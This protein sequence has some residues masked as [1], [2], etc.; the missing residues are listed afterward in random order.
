MSLAKNTFYS[1][2]TQLPVQFFGIIS[3]ILLTRM[4][5]VE[6]KGVFAIYNANAQ[7]LITFFSFSLSSSIAFFISSKKI[8]FEKMFGFGLLTFILGSILAIL[9]VILIHIFSHNSLFFPTEYHNVLYSLW[10]ITM[11]IVSIGISII[12]GFYVGL[13]R[14][15]DINRIAIVNSIVNLLCFSFVF[16]LYKY[17][18]VDASP[19]LLLYALFFITLFN[20]I[21]FLYNFI[22]FY[23]KPEIKTISFSEIKSIFN[24]TILS[25]L[26]IFVN[27]FN[28]RISLWVLAYYLDEF[29]IGIYSLAAN[30]AAIFSVISTPIANVMMPYLAEESKSIRDSI[31][32]R[33]S[34]LNFSV[35]LFVMLIAFLISD[36]LIPLVYGADFAESSLLFKVLLPGVLFSC[37]TKLF[38]SYIT[39]HGK[40][41]YNLIATIIGFTV[42]LILN[43]YLISVYNVIGASIATMC[44]YI[45]IYIVVSLYS[46]L[47]LGLPFTNYFF[48]TL[49][50]IKR[51]YA[52]RRKFL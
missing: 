15:K 21:Q 11:T 45:A 42:S 19:L 18:L 49:P 40:Q 6:G 51:I 50:D 26:S 30:V 36:F 10:L 25:H 52:E 3:G 37:Q 33:Y 20:F 44:T 34:R 41:Q 17:Q 31:F 47:R 38:A 5:G 24:F 16:F 12:T 7:L 39:S 43:I 23:K 22:K 14:F 29:S 1:F 4:L 9:T 46:H 28:Y 32:I 2:F 27:F 8:S 48:I 35:L 13:K